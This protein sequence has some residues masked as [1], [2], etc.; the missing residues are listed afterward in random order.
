MNLTSRET[1]VLQCIDAHLEKSKRLALLDAI[2]THFEPFKLSLT[3]IPE[4]KGAHFKNTAER[5][6]MVVERFFFVAL[7]CRRKIDAIVELIHYSVSSKNAVALAQ[8]AR[9]LV[10][11]IAVQVAIINALDQ[12]MEEIRGQT[13][14]LR[15]HSALQKAESFFN[16]C[17]FGKSS[18]VELDK[19]KQALHVNDCI[20]LLD[21]TMIGA[22]EAYD[23]L[24]EFVH[25]N[26]GSNSLV[27]TFNL[28]LQVESIAIKMSRT[29]VQQM[30]EIVEKSLSA[31]ENFD[32][33]VHA[34]LALLGGY[35]V[36][37]KDPKSRISN[38]FA[39]RKINPIGDG[40]SK[41]TAIFFAAAR[42]MLEH[43]EQW[44]IY[45]E[46]RKIVLYSRRVGA[47]ESNLVFDL[48][49]SS[50]GQLW[51]KI[52]YPIETTPDDLDR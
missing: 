26:H 42:D 17:Y 19:S 32:N 10:E 27:S 28:R 8:G 9:S 23:F 5:F 41:D 7:V 39:V 37:F 49:E 22:E 45:V 31:C 50:V 12:L 33:A 15:I 6:G 1:N 43:H 29:E 25:P 13:E 21:S 34:F 44:K 2:S 16:R 38:I 52:E 30:L 40:K 4:S 36:R 51:R 46:R 20:K 3:E 11:H 18:K 47:I 14:G 24:C 48:Y 35:G